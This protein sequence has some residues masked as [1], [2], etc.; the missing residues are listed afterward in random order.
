MIGSIKRRLLNKGAYIIS[1]FRLKKILRGIDRDSLVIDCGANVGDI[2]ALFLGRGAQVICFEPD[3]MAF[4]TLRKRF[5]GNPSI[6]L[7][8][9]AVS[10]QNGKASFYLH[11]DRGEGTGEEY[12]VSSSLLR[13]KKN[14]DAQKGIEVELTDLSEYISALGRNVDVLK[15]DVEGAEISILKKMI[16]EGTYA[17]IGIMLVETHETKI[18]GHD[19]E[20]ADIRELIREKGISNIGLNWV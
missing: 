9:S 12:T 5:G 4:S 14:V 8:N 1:Y 11:K 6:Q 15:L 7:L 20:V 19:R 18:P 16:R 2:T 3:P 13:E 10:D 17:K